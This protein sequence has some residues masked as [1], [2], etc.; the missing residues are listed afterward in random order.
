M[1]AQKVS[2]L[3]PVSNPSSL[4]NTMALIVANG[5]CFSCPWLNV[6]TAEGKGDPLGPS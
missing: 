3:Y 4:D 5:Y 6:L 1:P 2:A